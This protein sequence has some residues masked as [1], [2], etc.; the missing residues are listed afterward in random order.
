MYKFENQR[1]DVYIKLGDSNCSVTD[2]IF[3]FIKRM[4]AYNLQDTNDIYKMDNGKEYEV[5]IRRRA[6]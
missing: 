2:M 5:I 6:K 3:Y 1:S 4:E